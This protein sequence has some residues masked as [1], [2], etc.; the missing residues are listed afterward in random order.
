MKILDLEKL[1]ILIAEDS[2]FFRQ[3]LVQTLSSWG[4]AVVTAGSGSEAWEILQREDTPRLA[5][6]DWV[7]PGLSGL[8]VC[9]MVSGRTGTP[10]IY[11]ILL[12]SKDNKEDIVAGLEAGADDYITKPF[13]EEELR[14]R[15]KI[16]ERIIRLENKISWLAATDPL[17]GVLNRRAFME[18]MEGEMQ[19]SKRQNEPY[20]VIMVDIDHFKKINDT[21]G[22]QA[23]DTVLHRFAK[24]L[25]SLLRSY[26]FVGRY[27]GEEFIISLTG[28]GENQA[29][30]IAERLRAS[31]VDL[32]ITVSDNQEALPVTASF[33]VAGTAVIAEGT[34]DMLL[35]KAD[36]ALYRAKREG[37]N[38]VCS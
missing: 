35:T 5:I 2:I 8:E 27:G 11:L 20:S 33:G 21:Y 26:E 1:S 12:T 9:R 10:Y 22:H 28:T 29:V 18:R 32:A 23:G 15:V 17:T 13:H 6:L 31:L 37:R 14:C 34:G 4:Y 24:H 3:L 38:R 25:S 36:Q 7:M 16:G 30:R 19:R